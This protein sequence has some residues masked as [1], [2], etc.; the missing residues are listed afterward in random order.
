MCV[1]SV[2]NYKLVSKI[3]PPP[4]PPPH[5]HTFFQQQVRN[6]GYMYMYMQQLIDVHVHVVFQL[7]WLR[8][9]KL[10]ACVIQDMKT[11][12]AL[13]RPLPQLMCMY[14]HCILHLCIIRIT[15]NYSELFVFSS[16]THTT[17]PHLYLHTHIINVVVE[18]VRNNPKPGKAQSP[19]DL[20]GFV[21]W[22]ST[23]PDKLMQPMKRD[24]GKKKQDGTRKAWD[25]GFC[26]ILD[27]Y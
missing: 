11:M 17:D 1:W 26:F 4:P 8:R 7:Q 21:V 22:V 23:M 20:L 27:M 5:T 2:D 6:M 18:L 19:R 14:V 12:L 16:C 24:R 25:S 15:S 9:A 13:C 10:N 3:P